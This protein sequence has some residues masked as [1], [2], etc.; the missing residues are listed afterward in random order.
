MEE[1]RDIYGFEGYQVSNLGRVRSFWR[2]KHY[3]TGYGTYR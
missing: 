3:E 1:W 2:K